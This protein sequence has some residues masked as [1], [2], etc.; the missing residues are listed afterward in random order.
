MLNRHFF[1]CLI[2]CCL[3]TTPYAGAMADVV[4][5]T[6]LYRPLITL[7]IGP[8]FIQK[9]QAQTLSPLPPFEKYYTNSHSSTTILDGGGFIAVER[10]INDKCWVQWG[11]SGYADSQICPEGNVWLFASP[12]FDTLSYTYT[13][14]HA[15]VMAEGKFLTT[16]DGYQ[17]LHPYLSWGLGAAFNQASNYQETAF[18]PNAV[19]TLP[20][21]NNTQTSFTWSVGVGFDYTLDP[22]IRLG[23]G[24]QFADLGSVSL[25]PTLAE[26]TPQTLSLPHLYTNQLRFQFTY[27]M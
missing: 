22:Y 18:I 7:S 19:P 10:V 8:D 4:P 9:G 14:Q 12:E 17:T 6:S 25:G 11:V 5:I 24:Y 23:V 1:L 27:L 16:P 26:T 20:F 13:V 21:A 3:A 15:R 2:S